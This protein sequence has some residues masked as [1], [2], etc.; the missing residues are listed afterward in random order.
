MYQRGRRR[1]GSALP[2]DSNLAD[3][4][5]PFVVVIAPDDR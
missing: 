4:S 1:G 5:L 3:R 2:P